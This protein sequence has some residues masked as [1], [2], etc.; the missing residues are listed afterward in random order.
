MVF[1][2]SLLT[3]PLHITYSGPFWAFNTERGIHEISTEFAHLDNTHHHSNLMGL[4]SHIRVE[5][6]AVDV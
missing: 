4:Y 3:L 5:E 2:A 1:L 6:T